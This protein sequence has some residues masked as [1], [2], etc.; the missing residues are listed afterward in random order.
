MGGGGGGAT[1]RGCDVI[2]RLTCTAGTAGGDGVYREEFPG[3]T[4]IVREQFLAGSW[5]EV[6]VA[7]QLARA[8]TASRG[9]LAEETANAQRADAVWLIYSRPAQTGCGRLTCGADGVSMD[10]PV[11]DA[12]EQP[13]IWTCARG[14]YRAA[15]CE[16]RK[17]T[18]WSGSLLGMPAVGIYTCGYIGC[19]CANT[20]LAV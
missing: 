18:W 20:P 8:G 12:V 17:S 16:R 19:A 5:R 3:E 7:R 15:T 2:G 1:Q 6:P 9:K 13:H 11:G 14:C 4:C 10:I